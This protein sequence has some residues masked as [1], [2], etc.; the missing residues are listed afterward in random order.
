MSEQGLDEIR[1]ARHELDAAIEEI[2]KVP[3][4]EDFLA[5]PT[6]ADVA[7]AATP[8]PIVY[9]AAAAPG[10]LALVVRSDDVQHVPLDELTA[11]A[12][13]EQVERHLGTYES[14]RGDPDA[15]RS[16]WVESLDGLCAWLWRVAMGPVVK[17]IAGA[18]EAVLVA[19][20]L[21]GMLPLHAAWTDDNERP[22]GRQY[23]LDVLPLSYAPNARSLTSARA[24][25]S[26]VRPGRLLV[27]AEPR[28]VS[29]ARLPYASAEAE[30]STAAFPGPQMVLS[31]GSATP[32]NF[33]AGASAA[34]VLHLACHGFADLAQPLESGLRLAGDRA[35]T[36]RDLM[37]MQLQV[38]LAVLSAC[39]TSLPGMELPDEVVALP[40]GLLQAGVAG[41]VASMWTVPDR[42]T[43]ML[44]TDFYRRWRW[45]K[46]KPVHALRDAQCWMRDSTNEEK[47][48]VWREAGATGA[49]WLPP[50]VAEA[51]LRATAYAEPE[52]RDHAS[53]PAWGAFTHV[54]A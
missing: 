45:E 25:A 23:A 38:H 1:A 26:N 39:E 33:G 48:A 17:E 46:G 3:G 43:S 9:L 22:T 14:Y 16:A 41:V 4:F 31:G 49:Q 50:P 54:G 7:E 24:T 19:G 36:L 15:G 29:G 30:V 44:M 18:T 13:R 35:V 51:F 47:R 5:A 21:L 28:P 20:G 6:F 37:A 42:A 10:G 27:V 52:A 53:I 8:A 32:R 34:D 2:R 40:T 11:G 12:L